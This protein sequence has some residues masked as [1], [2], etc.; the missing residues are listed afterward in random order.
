MGSSIVVPPRV[1]LITSS[2]APA[3]GERHYLG[4][5]GDE[6]YYQDPYNLGAFRSQ[7]VNSYAPGLRLPAKLHGI[8]YI[9]EALA[10]QVIEELGPE[11]QGNISMGDLTDVCTVDELQYFL[12]TLEKIKSATP[13]NRVLLF[14]IGNHEVFHAGTTNSGRNFGSLLGIIFSLNMGRNY[15]DN[16]HGPEAGGND[17]VLDKDILVRTLY[18]FAFGRELDPPVLTQSNHQSYSL[19][20][21]TQGQWDN[22]EQV[23][24]DFWKQEPDGS[25]SAITKNKLHN[26]EARPE[27]RWVQT[28]AAKMEDL[29]TQNGNHPVYMIGL[30]TMD[31]TGIS[32]AVA[33][34]IYGYV[35]YEQVQRVKAFIYMKKKENP[36]AK[37]MLGGHHNIPDLAKFL[38][39]Q[40]SDILSDDDVI[41]YIGAHAH[42]RGYANLAD[43]QNANT[44]HIN[45]NTPLP[46]ITVPSV[47]D[48]PNEMMVL[49]YGVKNPQD[50]ELYFEFTFKSI[51]E[52]HL[53]GHTAL[54]DAEI[55]KLRPSFNTFASGLAHFDDP[56]TALLGS[57]KAN[58]WDKLE[59]LL[60]IDHGLI[61]RKGR[62]VDTAV[63]HDVIPTMVQANILYKRL[64]LAQI[65]ITLIEN[66]YSELALAIETAYSN[67]LDSLISYYEDTYSE[68]THSNPQQDIDPHDDH[69]DPLSHEQHVNIHYLDRYKDALAQVIATAQQ[70]VKS[71]IKYVQSTPHILELMGD[72][73][74]FFKDW[75]IQYNNLQNTKAEDRALSAM[76]NLFGNEYFGSIRSHLWE[77]PYGSQAAAFATLAGL[78]SARI[79]QAYKDGEADEKAKGGGQIVPD[80]IRFTVST[81]DDDI[82]LL[83]LPNPI[84]NSSLLTSLFKKKP[85]SMPIMLHNT[86]TGTHHTTFAIGATRS[87]G[88]N[89]Y[90][91]DKNTPI[92]GI[93][94]TFGLRSGQVWHFF[95][96]SNQARMTVGAEG[97]FFFD[98]QR[99]RLNIDGD[100]NVDVWR[101]NLGLVGRGSIGFG[102]PWGWISI[103][104]FVQTG[105]ALR[106]I[107]ED[108][109]TGNWGSFSPALVMG[110][111]ASIGFLD[112]ILTVD[113]GRQWY[114]GENN[115]A[116]KTVFGGASVDILALCRFFEVRRRDR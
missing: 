80:T 105:M 45:R 40:L 94:N 24:R 17:N 28:T 46:Q 112:G 12:T 35:S 67:Y 27:E 51:D 86:D 95:G 4:F 41:C 47:M 72:D 83:D 36:G 106:Q 31:Y 110:A 54:V 90:N 26:E 6:Q 63:A 37:F 13:L 59:T 64:A 92:N 38:Q 15:K 50:N 104:A 55:D 33:G 42:I 3:I 19:S 115:T 16:V 113:I 102:D 77:I 48:Y 52:D 44:Y 93:F 34:G 58:L 18:H 9:H 65:K 98:W 39:S 57:P 109:L 116:I 30:D 97:E 108:P 101:N 81:E 85:D 73:L 53:P 1:G 56:Q 100:R 29:Q 91:G 79:E 25:F 84:D 11:F 20:N 114:I 7:A 103:G 21:G 89:T 8:S 76:A 68:E 107:D 69:P 49:E 88:T 43:A 99:T 74:N 5:I 22:L 78:E 70:T 10:R 111:G 60:D 2:D 96:G 75:V 71:D 23:Y 32:S 61:L 66:G 82:S 87:D 14:L 62:L